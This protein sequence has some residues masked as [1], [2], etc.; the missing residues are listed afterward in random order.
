[1]HNGA[2]IAAAVVSTRPNSIE[3]Q[4]EVRVFTYPCPLF[5]VNMQILKEE[6]QKRFTMENEINSLNFKPVSTLVS[7][8]VLPEEIPFW[9]SRD[10]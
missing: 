3:N 2:A 7:Y 6:L 4:L 9:C 1:V 10:I 5:Q 8:F